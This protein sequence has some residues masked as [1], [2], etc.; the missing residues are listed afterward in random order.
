MYEKNQPESGL[1]F[2][3]D[4]VMPTPMTIEMEADGRQA[5]LDDDRKLL[6]GGIGCELSNVK[7]IG[8]H[9]AALDRLY[10]A[11]LQSSR[12]NPKPK[13]ECEKF[14]LIEIRLNDDG[15]YKYSR[16]GAMRCSDILKCI[17]YH[18]GVNEM[19]SPMVPVIDEYKIRIDAAKKR[20][21]DA[22]AIHSEWSEMPKWQADQFAADSMN[23]IEQIIYSAICYLDGVDGPNRAYAELQKGV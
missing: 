4:D 10:R 6:A 20:L 21:C 22:K 13:E 15:T 12:V 17:N 5:A 16:S 23:D 19:Q 7:A 8:E 18:C 11:S 1:E 9:L 3:K 14:A 2:S